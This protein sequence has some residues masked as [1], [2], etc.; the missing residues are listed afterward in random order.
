M[1]RKH[2]RDNVLIQTNIYTFEQNVESE[3]PF[4]VLAIIN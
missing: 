2:S 3:K 1:S 4:P